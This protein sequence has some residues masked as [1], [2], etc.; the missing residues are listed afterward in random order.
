MG[1]YDFYI[2][3]EAEERAQRAR[4][5]QMKRAVDLE[6]TLHTAKEQAASS[7]QLRF[8]TSI[9]EHINTALALLHYFNIKDDE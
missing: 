9:L 6:E 3:K 8:Q 4:D 7:P 5:E 2:E 1:H